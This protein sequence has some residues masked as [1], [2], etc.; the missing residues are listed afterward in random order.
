MTI[1]LIALAIVIFAALAYRGMAYLGW[2]TAI[3]IGL[4]AWLSGGVASPTAFQVTTVTYIVA[5]GLF[6]LTPLRRVVLSALLMKVVASILPK[7][8]ETERIALEAGTVWWD[9]DLFSGAP[10]WKKL[11][12]FQ[13]QPLSEEEQA[14]LDGPVEELCAMIDDWE[15]FQQRDLPEEVWVF[16]KKNKFFGMII[17]KEYGGLGFSAIAHSAVVTKIGSRSFTTAVTVMVPNSLGP[18]ELLSHYGTKEQKDHYL[19][20]LAIGEEVPCFAL[21]EPHAGSDAANGRSFGIVCKQ[22]WEGKETLGIR[23]TFAK[24]YITLAPVATVIGLAFR[25]EDPDHLLG[26]N[27]DVGITCALIPRETPGMIVGDRH[28]PLGIPFQ[29]G[30]VEGSDMFIPMDYIIGGAEQAGGGWRMLMDS[31]AAG[32]GI[33]LPSLSTAAAELSCRAISGYSQVREQFG[34]AIGRFEGVRE[35]L[36]SMAGHAYMMNAARQ[37]TAGAV[38]AGEKPSVVSAIVKAYMTEGMRTCINNAMD[39]QAGAAICGGQRNIF[40]RAYTSVPIGITVE[41]ANILTRSLIVF[42]QGAIRCH[43]FAYPQM[44]AA[45]ANDLKAFDAA[46][47]GHVNHITKNAV[48]SFVLAIT[49]GAFENAPVPGPEAKYYKKLTRYS[50]AFALIADFALM[51]LGGGLKSKEYL[52]GRLADAFGWMYLASATLKQF[53]DDGAPERDRPAVDWML[54]HALYQIETALTG[55]L[56]NLPSRP[57]AVVAQ[58]LAVPTGPSRQPPSDHQTDALMDALLAA[59]G[60]LRDALSGEIYIP[61]DGSPGLGDI[62]ATRTKVLAAEGAIAK[63]KKARRKGKLE[64]APNAQMAEAGL[65]AGIID[66]SEKALIDTAEAARDNVVQVDRFEADKYKTMR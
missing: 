20:R 24:R 27:E 29:N 52:S 22:Q 30:P 21:T 10:D 42:G 3:A 51:T 31:L 50:A 8:G 28:D 36:A 39:I 23:L 2:V 63:L 64:K 13:S 41:G 4:L 59:D 1:A 43:P 46:L 14:F 16:L 7:V 58:L 17:P 65:A 57:A 49:G 53:A 55:V 40:A 37:L 35:R 47:F 12:D 45:L 25:L 32:R 26:D 56:R 61:T 66:A 54:T 33:S 48:R 18:G 44:Q 9:G 6:G 60:K 15:I 62:E 38:D 11:L 19:A 5:V 34:T